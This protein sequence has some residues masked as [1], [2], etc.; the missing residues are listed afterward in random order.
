MTPPLAPRVYSDVEIVIFVAA[1]A[2]G[3]RLPVEMEKA[4]DAGLV[5]VLRA[6]P[7]VDAEQLGVAVAIVNSL[8]AAPRPD[9][10]ATLRSSQNLLVG[11]T[12]WDRKRIG[13]AV[14]TATAAGMI[15]IPAEGART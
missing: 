13:R 7:E 12:G 2:R 3:D 6:I 15:K 14:D 11:V 9:L 10:L 5:G 8:R 4:T 1:L